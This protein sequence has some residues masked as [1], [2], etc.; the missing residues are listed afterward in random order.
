[1]LLKTHTLLTFLS[2]FPPLFNSLSVPLASSLMSLSLSPS[3]FPL[4]T[5][6][7]AAWLRAHPQVSDQP[8]GAQRRPHRRLQ[9]G[10]GHVCWHP[11]QVWTPSPTLHSGDSSSSGGGGGPPCDAST[12]WNLH[13]WARG[14]VGEVVS[15]REM[16]GSFLRCNTN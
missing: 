8:A 3:L 13:G 7:K 16:F 11:E 9:V 15:E 6:Q 5:P 12:P 2:P 14:R 10:C 4:S 1:M